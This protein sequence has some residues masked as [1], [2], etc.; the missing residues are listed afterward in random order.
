MIDLENKVIPTVCP[1]WREVGRQLH[2]KTSILDE[3]DADCRVYGVNQK[4]LY[5]NV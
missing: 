3:I 2:L 4:M 1:L 5:K